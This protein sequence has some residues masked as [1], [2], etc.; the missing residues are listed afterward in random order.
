MN[1]GIK[2]KSA[3]LGLYSYLRTKYIQVGYLFTIHIHGSPSPRRRM[4]QDEAPHYLLCLN[5][6]FINLHRRAV[7]A[8]LFM[9]MPN[10]KCNDCGTHFD[11]THVYCPNCGCPKSYCTPLDETQDTTSSATVQPVLSTTKSE[12]TTDDGSESYQNYYYVD[13]NWFESFSSDPLILTL[14]TNVKFLKW[15]CAPWHI[16]EKNNTQNHVI[17]NDIFF[18]FNRFWK[19][20]VYVGVWAFCKGLPILLTY[21]IITFINTLYYDIVYH[22]YIAPFLLILVQIAFI[23]LMVIGFGKSCKR[24]GIPFIAALR[25]L[26]ITISKDIKNNLK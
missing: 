13:F 18:L 24:Y 6:S 4:R 3:L 8:L 12:K 11:A 2:W 7:D 15:L 19:L 10:Y 16:S 9:I 23:W 20:I 26:Y 5:L 14:L 25:H 1:T 22:T 21:I 17:A